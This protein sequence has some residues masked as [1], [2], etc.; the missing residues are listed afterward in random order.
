MRKYYIAAFVPEKEG[1]FSVYF[2]DVPGAVTG[3]YS[4][5]ECAEYGAD[6]LEDLLQELAAAKKPIPEPS[7]METVKRK[8]AKM[9]KESGLA[10][11]D[12]VH[13]QL[14]LAPSLDMVPVKITVSLPKAIL[15]EADKKAEV[16][17]FTRS[18]LLAQAVRAYGQ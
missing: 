5:E 2:P 4:L 6:I 14:F 12:D 9:R 15:E 1:S 3:G 11:P 16:Y 8:V 10:L 13:Y 18:G 7:N 17:G